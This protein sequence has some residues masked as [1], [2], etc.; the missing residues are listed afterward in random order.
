MVRATS[1][2]ALTRGCG[3]TPAAQT[4]VPKGTR[5]TSSA[6]PFTVSHPSSTDS[7][8]VPSSVL[9]PLQ[10]AGGGG[11]GWAGDSHPSW[12]RSSVGSLPAEELPAARGWGM[13]GARDPRQ[14]DM[15]GRPSDCLSVSLSTCSAFHLRWKCLV[16]YM[17]IC[18]GVVVGGGDRLGAGCSGY[19]NMSCSFHVA[20]WEPD[21]SQ[22]SGPCA[23]LDRQ[24]PACRHRPPG[25]AE[26]EHTGHA[27]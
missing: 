23:V 16:A 1:Q 5:L 22:G 8:L 14:L 4:H 7:T 24:P 27:S 26:P 17:A 15:G 25:W 21:T 12:P 19:V 2:P 18:V 6:A 13:G 9:M 10:G 3:A 11:G 20:T